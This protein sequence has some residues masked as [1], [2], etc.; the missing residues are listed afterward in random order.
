MKLKFRTKKSK[1]V[2]SLIGI[3]PTLV[4][5]SVIMALTRSLEID[6]KRVRSIEELKETPSNLTLKEAKILL[7]GKDET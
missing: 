1:S 6:F 5:V 2:D 4:V 3:L 7:G